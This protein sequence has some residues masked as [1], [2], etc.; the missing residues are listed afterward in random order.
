MAR[1]LDRGTTL[2]GRYRLEELVGTGGMGSVYAAQ[3]LERGHRVAVK[4]LRRRY[5][6][7]T[8]FRERFVAESRAAAQL[9]H[10]HILTVHDHGVDDGWHY[11]AMALAPTD[12]ASLVERGGA[13]GAAGLSITRSLNLAEQIA[14]ALD[15]AH[16]HGLVHRDVKPENVLVAPRRDETEPDHAYLADFGIA[17]LESAEVALT[18]T[19]VFVGTASYA[20]P[21]QVAGHDLDGRSDQ[22]AL[23]CVLVECLTGRPPFRG[24]DAD[25]VLR[26]H[27]AAPRPDVSSLRPG[28]PVA[29]D[30]VLR[31][32]LAVD[33]DDR[34]PTC[35]ALVA[36]AR[37]AVRG[38]SAGETAHATTVASDDPGVSGHSRPDDDASRRTGPTRP[39]PWPTSPTVPGDGRAEAAP[40]V[41]AGSA[42]DASTAPHDRFP[43]EAP[44]SRRPAAGAAAPGS[45][46]RRPTALLAAAAVTATALVA[47]VVVLLA[48]GGG[49]DGP[50]TGP[51]RSGPVTDDAPA[52]ERA[53]RRSVAAFGAARGAR[54]TCAVIADSRQ[55]GCASRYETAQPATF[56]VR[57]VQLGD[58]TATV[59]AVHEPDGD[60]LTFELTREDGVWRLSEV[61]SFDWKDPDEA[62]V[63]ETVVRF[64]SRTDGACAL[65]ASPIAGQCGTLLPPTAVSYDLTS[66]TSGSTASVTG[67]LLSGT[68]DR[69][70]LADVGD[71]WRITAIN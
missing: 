49:D 24:A 21:E 63:A 51:G 43:G 54:A 3:D 64:A 71:G 67:Q 35:A 58:D 56:A 36:A 7:R 61:P 38:G 44:S 50:P 28:L 18:Q 42:T 1:A 20:S 57:Q 6:E 15:V 37:D 53:V 31:R 52:A 4:V 8:E 40:T 29:L 60:R 33:R 62:A 47:A 45:R 2:G 39:G 9:P 48:S 69:Y 12:L 68:T 27:A 30:A 55:G 13:D 19:G 5:A 10:P 46:S 59:A 32:G 26:A 22:Y 66:V 70:E 16:A 11:I 25:A 41:A 17:K 23:A 65:L 34:Y 14:W